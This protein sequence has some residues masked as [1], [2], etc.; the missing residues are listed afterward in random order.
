MTNMK[1]AGLVRTTYEIYTP[2]S[3]EHG[4][5]EERG[6]IDEEGQECTPEE[7]FKMCRGCEPSG[8]DFHPGVWYIDNEYHTDYQTGAQ[9]SRSYHLNGFTHQQQEDIFDSVEA[10][11][12]VGPSEEEG[13]P[14]APGEN[15][16]QLK[17][18]ESAVRLVA[19][20]K[21]VLANE[22]L[23]GF[24]KACECPGD[25]NGCEG[26]MLAKDCPCEKAKEAVAPPG[27]EKVVKKL[28]KDPDIDNPW[29][30]A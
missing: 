12:W 21:Q 26:G 2:E 14:E 29:A 24:D 15:P 19:L 20:A 16:N 4:D 1:T 9:E 18:F 8:S 27:F 23:E 22:Q 3:V 10:G 5:A 11:H 17:L 7:A 30:L 28:K 13:Y 25:C 6:W